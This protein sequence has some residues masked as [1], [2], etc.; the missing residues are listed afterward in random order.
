MMSVPDV[1]TAMSDKAAK[2]DSSFNVCAAM[3]YT[4][5]TDPKIDRGLGRQPPRVELALRYAVRGWFDVAKGSQRSRVA[6]V[7]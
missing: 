4:D 3:P 2:A 5:P 1:Q 6:R 7:A